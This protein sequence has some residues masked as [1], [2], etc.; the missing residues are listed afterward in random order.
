MMIEIKPVTRVEGHLYVKI[1]VRDGDV[2]VELRAGGFRGFEKILVGRPIEEAPNIAPRICGVCPVAHHLA[3]VKAVDA[4]LGVEPPRASRIVREIMGLGGIAQSHLLH[5]GFLLYP[6]I[7]SGV[8]DR[9]L[10]ST[11]IFKMLM[12]LRRCA[13]RI[14]DVSGGRYVHPFNAVPGGVLRLPSRDDVHVLKSEA[15]SGIRILAEVYGEIMERI[16]SFIEGNSAEIAYIRTPIV[17]LTGSEGMEFYD[18][19]VKIVDDNH[20]KLSFDPQRYTDFV[21]EEPI[22]YSYSKRVYIA[23]NGVRKVF[24]VGP[25]PRLTASL[26]IPY[27]VTRRLYRESES[28]IR[29]WPQHPLLYNLARVIEISYCFEKIAALLDELSTV[30]SIPR[31]KITLKGGRGIGIVE[32]PRGLL[33]HHYECSENG[34][35]TH[36][37]LVIPTAMN[38]PSMERDIRETVRLLTDRHTDDVEYVKRKVMYLVRSY[39]P[40]ISCAT[41][42]IHISVTR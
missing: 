14:V 33:I 19:T 36:A 30:P 29:R 38:I 18:S 31:V 9:G 24:R 10:Y 7:E 32:A 34:L 42:T 12:T 2:D 1:V 3:S 40:C 35:I 5:L 20:T 28:L 23:V 4:A 8:E 15:E 11:Q 13:A 21:V 6:D 26:E 27:E 25:L 16:E 37:N 41:H 17:V 39:D 22:E